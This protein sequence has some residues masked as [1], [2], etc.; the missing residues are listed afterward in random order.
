MM[1]LSVHAQQ[2]STDASDLAKQTQNPVSSL[3]SVPFQNNF[4]FGVGPD[5]DLQYILNIQPVIPVRI[6][7]K[8]NLI[9]RVIAPLIYQP[10]LAPGFGDEFGLG[11]IQYQGFLSPAKPSKLIWGIGPVF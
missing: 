1:P 4:N 8:W 3:I 11:D 10:E 5:D 9:N 6:T 7:E 2:S